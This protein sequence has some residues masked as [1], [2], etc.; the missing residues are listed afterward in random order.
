MLASLTTEAPLRDAYE[1]ALATVD[2]ASG[3]VSLVDRRIFAAG[4]VPSATCRLSLRRPPGDGGDTALAIFSAG[5]SRSEPLVLYSLP[6]PHGQVFDLHVTLEAPGRVRI[7]SPPGAREYAGTWAQIRGDIPD[8]VDIRPGPANLVCAVDLAGPVPAVRHRLRLVRSLLEQLMEEYDEPGWLRVSMLTCTDH[9]FERGREYRPVVRG[10]PLSPVSDALAWFSRQERA[11]VTYA[12][13]APIE[14]LLHEASIMLAGS[15]TAH[16]AARL[17]LVGG[18]RPH[19]YPQGNG[20]VMRCPLKYKWRQSLRQLTG[21]AGRAAWRWLTPSRATAPRPR[22]GRNS[23]PPGCTS[24]P[25]PRPNAWARISRSSSRTRSGYRF[26][27][28]I[29]NE[30]FRDHSVPYRIAPQQGA[31]EHRLVG[32]DAV[33][34]DHLPGRPVH[35]CEPLLAEPEHLRSG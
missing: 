15:R 25:V 22:S 10:I 11:D 7:D 18:R 3:E 23:A 9:N 13:A 26:R 8:R 6:L 30:A 31:E 28:P 20:R 29:R 35:R 34:Q 12:P 2:E 5:G 17:L 21:E 24:C 4:D 16:R 14:D 1:L 33:R 27:C 32:S 19:P